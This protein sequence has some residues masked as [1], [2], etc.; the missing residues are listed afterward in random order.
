ML[1]KDVIIVHL[2]KSVGYG[3]LLERYLGERKKMGSVTSQR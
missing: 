1:C 2:E 3:A